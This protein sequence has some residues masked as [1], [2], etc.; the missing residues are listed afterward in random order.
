MLQDKSWDWVDQKVAVIGTGATG[1]QVVP[2]V[3]P[4]VRNLEVYVRSPT[5]I[6]PSVGFGVE[7]AIFNEQ[8]KWESNFKPSEL[9]SYLRHNG[10]KDAIPV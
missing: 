10:T 5:Y 1:I 4:R 9:I 2:K 7:S 6:L 3:Q 8:C